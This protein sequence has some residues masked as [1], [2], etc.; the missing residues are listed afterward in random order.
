MLAESLRRKI[1][2]ILSVSS[3]PVELD[4]LPDPPI[5]RL[6]GRWC[7]TDPEA[8]S[9]DIPSLIKREL[10]AQ[11][12]KYMHSREKWESDKYF[13]IRANIFSQFEAQIRD[14]REEFTE[15]KNGLIA[16]HEAAISTLKVEHVSAMNRMT[17]ELNARF[18]A[19][20]TEAIR[21]EKETSRKSQNDMLERHSYAIG[22]MRN[23]MNKDTQFVLDQVKVEHEK[24]LEILRLKHESDM[25]A[26]REG[27]AVQVEECERVIRQKLSD[28]NRLLIASAIEEVANE[29][30]RIIEE[31][32]AEVKVRDELHSDELTEVN[33]KLTREIRRGD[34]MELRVRE[35]EAE[36]LRQSQEIDRLRMELESLISEKEAFE[37]VGIEIENKVQAVLKEKNDEIERLRRRVRQVRE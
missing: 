29:N 27:L 16:A 33:T 15:E 37:Q 31:R 6:V 11:K 34:M 3:D 10:E 22:E 8:P 7:Q 9:P 19:E 28:E 23:A 14:L 12:K 2:R 24:Q 5:R 4:P 18:A 35:R 1:D 30:Q 36:I 32:R 20:L 17:Q 25:A 26:C 13:E 21:A